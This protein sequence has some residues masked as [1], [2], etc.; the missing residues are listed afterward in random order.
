MDN[1][2]WR[3]KIVDK[4]YTDIRDVYIY[5]RVGMNKMGIV[6]GDTIVTLENGEITPKPSLVL[7]PSALQAFSDALNSQGFKPQAGFLE[8]KLG[9]T[10]KHLEDMRKLVFEPTVIIEKKA[11]QE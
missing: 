8:G 10:E 9:A 4:G 7:S 2:E 3:V 5:C 11:C 1:N 6:Y